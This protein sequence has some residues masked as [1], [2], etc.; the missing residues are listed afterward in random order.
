MTERA[1]G[2]MAPPAL[3][4]LVA[5][6][7]PFGQFLLE[8]E[9]VKLGLLKWP[10]VAVD[11]SSFLDPAVLQR[12]RLMSCCEKTA[13]QISCSLS[14]VLVPVQICSPAVRWT[15]QLGCCGC[16]GRDSGIKRCGNSETKKKTSSHLFSFHLSLFHSRCPTRQT[17]TYHV[18]TLPQKAR[19]AA[20]QGRNPFIPTR[21]APMYIGLV[22]N[23]VT[24]HPPPIHPGSWASFRFVLDPQFSSSPSLSTGG[25]NHRA[26]A[27]RLRPCPIN[28]IQ[29]RQRPMSH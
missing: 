12:W 17:S 6:L 22:V 24:T 10:S 11:S 26:G 27:P 13:V 20:K 18:L 7:C 23:S 25:P 5:C 28:A 15:L 29:A 4:R 8:F 21:T 2:A 14:H 16:V 9:L 19:H 3:A 1:V